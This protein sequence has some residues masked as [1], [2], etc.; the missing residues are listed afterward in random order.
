[1]VTVNQQ[2]RRPTFPKVPMALILGWVCLVYLS[3]FQLMKQSARIEPALPSRE[4]PTLTTK[5][6]LRHRKLE[7]I[8]ITKTGGTAVEQAGDRAGIV[9][10]FCHFHT[11]SRS[12]PDKMD[13]VTQLRPNIAVPNFAG[14]TWHTPPS[15]FVESP[16]E[17]SDTFTIVRNPYERYLS[18]YYCPFFGVHRPGGGGMR[19]RLQSNLRRG[20]LLQSRRDMLRYVNNRK[21]QIKQQPQHIKQTPRFRPRRRL[22]TQHGR[23]NHNQTTNS[24]K[25]SPASLNKWLKTYLGQRQFPTRT[26]HLLPQHFYVYDADGQVVDHVLKFENLQ[27]E[28]PALMHHY[29]LEKVQLSTQPVNSGKA[30]RARMNVTDMSAETI[31][32]INEYAREDFE[33]FGYPMIDPDTI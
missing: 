33:L 3:S 13:F 28:F 20:G 15:W 17:G 4:T 12:P 24:E 32:L 7:F 26:G 19:K 11:C 2:R 22:T 30:T 9:W 16:Y 29:G 25:E 14:E 21:Y 23:T 8:H 27:E 18:E 6:T 10:G 5:T 31:R 1:M